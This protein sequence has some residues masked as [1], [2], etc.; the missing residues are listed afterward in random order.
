MA[1]RAAIFDLHKCRR[2]A[3]KGGGWVAG[4]A[5]TMTNGFDRTASTPLS[6]LPGTPPSMAWSTGMSTPPL[7]LD[8]IPLRG[9][10]LL[11]PNAGPGQGGGGADGGG[12]RGGGDRPF[13]PQRNFSVF[14]RRSVE[15]GL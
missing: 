13:A 5:A 2:M 14:A 12:G 11:S 10:L 4:G 7:T 15:S 6:T 8:A 1:V 9:A 3:N